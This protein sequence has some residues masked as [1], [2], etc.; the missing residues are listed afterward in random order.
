MSR[1]ALLLVILS[2]LLL[3]ACARHYR[4]QGL[5]LDV[6]R[7]DNM[8]VVSHRAVPGYM[9]AMTMPFRVRRASELD[10]LKRGDQVEF[11]LVVKRRTSLAENVRAGTSAEVANA[12][13]GEAPLPLPTPAGKLALG[14]PVP[15]F[16]L[17]NQSARPVRLSDFAGRIIA[18]N[19][20][21]TR[22]PLP[23]VCPRLSANFAHLQKRFRERMGKDLALLSIT[24]DS[25]HDT[26][27]VLTDYAKRWGAGD[28]WQFLTGDSADIQRI[29][30]HFG[31]VYWP[32]DGLLTHT[33]QTGIIDRDGRLAALIEGSSYEEDQLGDLIARQ[34]EV[35]HDSHRHALG[36]AR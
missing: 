27:T 32:E 17:V 1:I 2:A 23:E 24:L 6:N 12:R 33:S 20:I 3:F 14:E 16:H 7:N 18:V 36:A 22:C 35:S 10:S 21:Y 26:S 31:L 34:L 13:R 5:V 15:D 4:V 9:D 25:R 8:M 19:F 11:Q 28:G 30:N 29:A